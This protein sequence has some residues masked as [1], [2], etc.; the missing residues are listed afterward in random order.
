MT[1]QERIKELDKELE[2]RITKIDEIA[3]EITQLKKEMENKNRLWVPEEGE[4]HYFVCSNGVVTDTNNPGGRYRIYNAFPTRQQALK[5]SDYMRK[6]N[7]I[8]KACLQVDPHFEPDWEDED[9]DKWN[10]FFDHRQGK[11][12]TSSG[13]AYESEPCYVST[14]KKA[15]Q[16]ADILNREE[17]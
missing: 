9:Q 15:Q 7:M 1:T 12:V 10:V 3:S 16:V 2:R 5:A 4:K 8:I 13:I 17:V 6:S 11:W 14:E